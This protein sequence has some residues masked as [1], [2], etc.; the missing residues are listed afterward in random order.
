M[1]ETILTS[2]VA[3]TD[4]TCMYKRA[5]KNG[6]I[7]KTELDHLRSWRILERHLLDACI[8]LITNPIERQQALTITRN[9]IARKSLS[10]R[11]PLKYLKRQSMKSWLYLTEP[12]PKSLSKYS[13]S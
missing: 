1:V 8:H 2:T 6:F 12:A 4:Q 10:K 3:G 9:Y 11:N 7:P 13:N 5:G